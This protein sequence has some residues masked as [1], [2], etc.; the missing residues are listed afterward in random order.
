VDRL[1]GRSYIG[2]YKVGEGARPPLACCCPRP[3]A[4]CCPSCP[5]SP[6]SCPPSSKAIP[7]PP[8]NELSTLTLQGATVGHNHALGGTAGIGGSDGE[9]EGGGL[10]LEPG[11]LACADL[12]TVIAGN[13]AS[14]S[15]DDVSGTLGWC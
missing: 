8:R 6:V 15:D 3:R 14:T 11:G 12:L 1:P 4:V 5:T 9:G 2:I 7:R 13:H 10:Y